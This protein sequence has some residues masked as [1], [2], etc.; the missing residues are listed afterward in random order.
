MENV[1]NIK[2]NGLK[3]VKDQID[4]RYA[5]LVVYNKY[6]KDVANSFI[7]N[8]LIDLRFCIVDGLVVRPIFMNPDGKYSFVE[9]Y[10]EPDFLQYY[11]LIVKGAEFNDNRLPEIEMNNGIPYVYSDYD[12]ACESL[13][14]YTEY[15][16]DVNNITT[17]RV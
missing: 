8:I 9:L 13:K 1:Y 7:A 2:G 15:T 6:P 3:Y 16:Q 12:V 14:M 5:E 10:N 11:A 17:Y 4:I